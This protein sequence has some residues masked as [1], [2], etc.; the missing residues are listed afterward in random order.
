MI[1]SARYMRVDSVA[2]IFG[3]HPRTVKNWW[4]SGK[5]CLIAWHPTH[6]I[7]N[8]LLFTVESVKQFEELGQV[9]EL[10]WVDE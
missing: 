1:I 10:L 9:D 2:K 7:G 4:K 3:V 5:T 6:K 8:G